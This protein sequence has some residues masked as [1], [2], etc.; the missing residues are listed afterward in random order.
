MKAIFNADD[1]GLS[2]GVNLGIIE[3]YR[4]GVV[5]STTI[6]AGMPGFEHAVSL[7]GEYP[8]LKIGIHLTLTAGKSVG[9]VYKTLT[10]CDGHFLPLAEFERLA[11]SGDI[12][13]HEVESECEAQIHKVLAAGITPDHFDSHHHTH[14]LPGIFTVFL[15]L[16]GKYGTGAR[17]K[18]KGSLPREYESILTT[19]V[20][21]DNFYNETATPENLR[22]ILTDCGG[23]SLEIMCH[24]AFVDYYQLST[25]SYNTRRAYELHILTSPEIADFMVQRGIEPCSYS[26]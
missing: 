17:I 12:D 2:K 25:C 16:A 4:N 18:D 7:S 8:G 14:N 20:F 3:S 19:D 24:P 5:R 9:G 23:D 13:L 1:F 10:D 26:G 15:K 6:M 22:K 21:S 11:N